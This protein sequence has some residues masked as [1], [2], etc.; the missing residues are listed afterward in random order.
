MRKSW[1][2]RLRVLLGWHRWH[3][4]SK[5]AWELSVHGMLRCHGTSNSEALT[6]ASTTKWRPQYYNILPCQGL[7]GSPTR[8]IL[9]HLIVAH[10]KIPKMGF[11]LPNINQLECQCWWQEIVTKCNMKTLLLSAS[12]PTCDMSLWLNPVPAYV[13][14]FENGG[15]PLQF[16]NL[17]G[18]QFFFFSPSCSWNIRFY[19]FSNRHPTDLLIASWWKIE[20]WPLCCQGV[21]HHPIVFWTCRDPEPK[22][23]MK[24]CWV[25]C[26]S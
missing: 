14:K 21:C 15:Y 12:A 5:R 1:R 16:S 19:L 24:S 13:N 18:L 10:G 8:V 23:F 17:S 20:F 26:N 11:P 9:H 6:G 3:S 4:H 25:F 2:L 22:P 7:R